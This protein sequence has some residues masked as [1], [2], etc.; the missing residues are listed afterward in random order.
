MLCPSTSAVILLGDNNLSFRA[1][2]ET[3]G[4]G[5]LFISKD[6]LPGLPGLSGIRVGMDPQGSPSPAHK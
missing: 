4:V 2:V 6:Q 3:A 5:C 1:S